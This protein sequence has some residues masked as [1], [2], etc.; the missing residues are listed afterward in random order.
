MI[1]PGILSPPRVTTATTHHVTD[2][3]FGQTNRSNLIQTSETHGHT[4]LVQEQIDIDIGNIYIYLY[5]LLYDDRYRYR[6]IMVLVS[7]YYMMIDIDIGVY[8]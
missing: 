1:K 4:L 8:I 2:L 6:Y 3:P 7:Y 5:I